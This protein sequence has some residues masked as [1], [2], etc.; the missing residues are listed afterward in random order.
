LPGAGPQIVITDRAT[1]TFDNDAR[2]M[3]LWELAPG[4]T[5]DSIQAEV[6]WP[7]HLSPDMR[8]MR[9]PDALELDIIRQQLDPEGRY[10]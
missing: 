5:V 6:S 3:M 2:E 9:P 8:G 4:E 10:R 7:L 1:F